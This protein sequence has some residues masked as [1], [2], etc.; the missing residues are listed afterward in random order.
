MTSTTRTTV[1]TD[2]DGSGN[3]DVVRRTHVPAPRPSVA[4]KPFDVSVL[5][6]TAHSASY[7]TVKAAAGPDA[8]IVAM[9]IPVNSHFPTAGMFAELQAALPEMLKYYPSDSALTTRKLAE[10]LGLDPRTMAMGNG[11][12]ELITWI[13]HLLI[14]ESVAIPIPTFGRWTDQP[15][16]TGKRVDMY[17]LLEENGFALDID[18]YIAFI[19]ERDSR[20]AVICNPNNPD[21][22]YVRR[23]DIIRFLDELA[24]LDLVV[25]DES[26]IDFVDVEDITSVADEAARRD[27]V[28]V[29]RS[30]GKNFGMHGIRF[31][32]QVSSPALAERIGRALPKWNLNA[33]AETVVGMIGENWDAYQRSLQLVAAEREHMVAELRAID[34]LTVF[35]P[36]SNFVLVKIPDGWSGTGLRDHLMAAHHV[37]VRDCGNKVG[38]TSAFMRFAVHPADDVARLTDGI[39][40]YARQLRQQHAA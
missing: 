37:Y 1:S 13:D 6:A 2:N 35:P 22:G 14:D 32:Y 17:P 40:D 36:S 21:G 27:N 3:I 16:E 18:E 19:R 9:C 28:I 24:D 20:I 5:N 31:G 25:I 34:G 26:F 11:S 15:A 8:D 30:L 33:L 7:A 29:L 10:V 4:A 39:R 12:T 23:A 38:M